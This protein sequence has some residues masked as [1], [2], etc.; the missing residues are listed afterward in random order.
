MYYV[1]TY[2]LSR[3]CTG[4]T[5][6]DADKSGEKPDRK[7][8]SSPK[9]ERIKFFQEKGTPN[10][11]LAEQKNI[12]H[13]LLVY[14]LPDSGNNQERALNKLITNLSSEAIGDHGITLEQEH[15]IGAY[16]IEQSSNKDKQMITRLTVDTKETKENIRKAAVYARR[17]GAAGRHTVFLRDTL[18]E[19]AAQKR[20]RSSS[21]EDT[22]T[23]KKRR[24][25]DEETPRSSRSKKEKSHPRS[26]LDG[27][28]EETQ[29]KVTSDREELE[30]IRLEC[31]E[32][33][34]VKLKHQEREDRET[35]ELINKQGQRQK[36]SKT[37]APE[38]KEKVAPK[39]TI[40]TFL[41]LNE[42]ENENK[43]DWR[44]PPTKK[45]KEPPKQ[46]AVPL[47]ESETE[48]ETQGGGANQA[49]DSDVG[50]DSGESIEVKI[51]RH[52]YEEDLEMPE[53]NYEYRGGEK[54]ELETE[55]EGEEEEVEDGYVEPS[56][57]RRVILRNSKTT[58]RNRR[59][60]RQRKLMR[61]QEPILSVDEEEDDQDTKV[62]R[63][64][65]NYR[66]Q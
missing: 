12:D 63:N 29:A 6:K 4:R 60:R 14:G 35:Q 2:S 39:A 8:K 64:K 46:E 24:T 1:L 43:D 40:Q 31:L 11:K 38:N 44:S 22:K 45:D 23:P 10:A 19:K 54:E 47:V 50:S 53:S 37:S 51:T 56:P 28:P 55:G 16:H 59:R 26:R 9:Q 33:R 41:A 15:I 18:P 42:N 27:W 13:Q 61:D 17:W 21:N 3:D 5:T 34:R 58:A 57:E 48:P 7:R 32:A 20:G 25:D 66:R 49:E 65:K 52:E 30:K 36:E 62:P